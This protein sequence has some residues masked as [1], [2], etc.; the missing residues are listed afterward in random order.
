[1]SSFWGIGTTL[2]GKADKKE[3]PTYG[4]TYVTTKWFIVCYLPLIPLK[5]MRIGGVKTKSLFLVVYNSSTTQYFI[6]EQVPLNWAQIAR[7]FFL[8]W[9]LVALAVWLIAR[10]QHG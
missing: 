2:Y 7:T 4:Q 8:T 3:D 5:S 6:L 1:M 10:S 9:G